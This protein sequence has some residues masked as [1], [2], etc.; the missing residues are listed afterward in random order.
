MPRDPD[1]NLNETPIGTGPFKFVEWKRNQQ[2]EIV[3]N[4]DFWMEG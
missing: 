1:I 3:R 2:V 4:D